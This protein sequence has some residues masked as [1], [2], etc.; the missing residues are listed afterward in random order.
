MRAA[1]CTTRC[2]GEASLSHPVQARDMWTLHVRGQEAWRRQ[3][4]QSLSSRSSCLVASGRPSSSSRHLS[5]S[6]PGSSS[7]SSTS[8]RCRPHWVMTPCA[9]GRALQQVNPSRGVCGARP[10][11]AWGAVALTEFLHWAPSLPTTQAGT[12]HTCSIALHS[13]TLFVHLAGMDWEMGERQS[14]VVLPDAPQPWQVRPGSA[15]NE[16]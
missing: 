1:G 15:S 5:S 3:G 13:L 11:G 10:A 8:L 2:T 7:S 9:T 4:W 6:S 14:P 12:H 16:P